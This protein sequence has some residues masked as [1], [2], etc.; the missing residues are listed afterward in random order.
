VE[1]P[2]AFRVLLKVSDMSQWALECVGRDQGEAGV[3][4][5]FWKRAFKRRPRCT[6]Q[7]SIS[8]FSN[9]AERG[10]LPFAFLDACLSG[11]S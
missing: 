7:E 8:D 3:E 6:R 9:K 1:L 10:W 11:E 5:N 4:T 2:R